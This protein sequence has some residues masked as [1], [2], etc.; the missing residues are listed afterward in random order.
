VVDNFEGE[1]MDPVIEVLVLDTHEALDAGDGAKGI[2]GGLAAGDF[3]DDAF[4]VV[5][6]ANDGGGLVGAFLIGDNDRFIPL[7]D[8]HH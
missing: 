1:V 3:A 4:V 7:N 8:C 6:E 5:E 2:G